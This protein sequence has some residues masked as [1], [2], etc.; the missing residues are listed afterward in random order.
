[1]STSLMLSLAA[2]VTLLPAA[3]LPLRWPEQRNGLFWIVVA[4]GVGGTLIL[5]YAL[6]S[7]VWQTG[8]AVS[9][10]ITIAT[11]MALFAVLAFGLRD[12]WRLGALLVPYLLLL[13]VVATIW[14]SASVGA[15]VV[16]LPDPWL[17]I[18]I[19]AAVLT[20][21][22]V[23]LA[24]VAGLAVLLRERAVRMK[25]ASNFVRILPS[26]ADAERLQ[27]VLLTGGVVVLGLGLITGI[28][29]QYFTTGSIIVLDHKV[30]FSIAAFVIIG[31]LVVVHL[32]S[33]IGGRRVA[34]LAL[35]A[36]LLLTLG[37][38]GVKFVTDVLLAGA[39]AV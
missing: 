9:L 3:V 39:G 32:R 24:A 13:G 2:L 38:P 17:I 27:T 6:T 30:L 28:G 8:F 7:G 11:T 21:A 29:A 23:T 16:T 33:G 19:V 34:R 31:V 10:W 20:Y 4:I 1:M 18:H 25:S 35:L 36:Y 12:C 14:S 37:F 26:I 15:A 5:S 22:L